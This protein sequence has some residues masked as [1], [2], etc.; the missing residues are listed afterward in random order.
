M[1]SA[2]GVFAFIGGWQI[3]AGGLFTGN[4][5]IPTPS[6]IVAQILDDGLWFYLSLSMETFR[7][8]VQGY[9]WGNGFAILLAMVVVLV[10]ALQNTILL[11]G[12]VSYCMPIVA[13][14]PVLVVV[15]SGSEPKVVL[16]A[17]SVFFTTLLGAV[18]GL[19]S[20]DRTALDL[21]H[22]FGGDSLAALLKVRIHSALP[23][24]FAALRIAAPAAV[25]GAIVAEYMGAEYGLGV[26]IINAQQAM[27]VNRTWAVALAATALAGV[28][29]GLASL[30]A[31]ILTPWARD[32]RTDLAVTGPPRKRRGPTR[33]ALLALA[34]L[35][36]SIGCILAVWQATLWLLGVPK[37][38]G[39][40]PADVWVY[41]TDP[42][43]FAQ[44]W[45]LLWT[46]SLILLRDAS[47]GLVSGT[48][49]AL[50]VSILFNLWP[51]LQRAFLGLA[52]ALRAI[53]LVAMTP[54]IVLVFGRNLVTI[55]VI[56]GVITFFPTLVN[57]T[58]ALAQ[59]SRQATD[60]VHVYGGTR[61]H[62]LWKVQIPS[63]LPALFTS[64]RIAAPLATTG[65][66]MAAWL[67]TGKGLGYALVTAGT[68]SDYT[69]LWSRVALVTTFSIILYQVLEWLEQLVL[70]RMSGR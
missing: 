70:G 43:S 16:A 30:A 7:S 36:F 65:A 20:S 53:P 42:V 5:T 17:L 3:V 10:P 64:L 15:L 57:V 41:L 69:G 54:I 44:R 55:T 26:A 40:G 48:L 46:E 32:V 33:T 11:I 29:Y 21:V 6:G 19:R 47:L 51:T 8:A 68:V 1:T 13:I 25:L 2:V 66:M 18:A 37:F 12:V 56:G 35:T 34:R 60:L 22:A 38:I 49:A 4:G 59:A 31:A 45:A 27:E 58:L 62:Q 61:W 63:A 50:V 67:A 14:G 28:G 24:L 39:K 52:I 9:L 23:S